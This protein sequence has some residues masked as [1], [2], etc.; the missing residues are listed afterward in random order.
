M[1]KVLA[2]TLLLVLLAVPAAVSA[3]KKGV[4]VDAKTFPDVNFR[5]WVRW[6]VCGESDF[7]PDETRLG[8]TEFD[9]DGYLEELGHFE[10]LK[11]IEYFPN[12]KKLT[13][14]HVGLKKL[15]LSG[16]P[17]LEYLKCAQNE[18]TRLDLSGNP[19]LK[20]VDCRENQLREL[21]VS[22]CVSL[23]ELNCSRNRLP[24]LDVSKNKQLTDLDCGDNCL[25]ALDISK[26]GAL[27]RLICSDN[28]M[29]TLDLRTLG[30][31]AFVDCRSNHLYRID[32]DE[33]DPP[34]VQAALSSYPVTSE[35][36]KVDLK[37]IP[38]FEYDKMEILRG[39][40]LSGS[41]LTLDEEI[42]YWGQTVA[43]TL[44]ITRLSDEYLSFEVTVKPAVLKTVT[45][46]P[47]KTVYTGRPAEPRVTVKAKLCGSYYP[48]E[49]GVD[50][51]L[52]YS[53]NVEVG[54]GHVTVTGIGR[55]FTG[56]VTKKFT[57]APVRILKAELSRV[58]MPYTGKKQTPALTVTAKVD[59][60]TVTLTE[61][62]DYTVTCM[63]NVDAGTGR[64][65]VKGVGRFTGTITKR[66][67][68]TRVRLGSASV[69]SAVIYTGGEQTPAP[70]VKASV[71]GKTRRLKAGRDYTV[72]YKRNVDA[73]TA[74]MT[75]KGIG[76]YI[77]TIKK[78]FTV[79]P[80]KILYAVLDSDI[81]PWTGEPVTPAPTVTA[82]VGGETVTLEEGKDYTVEY[83][84]NIDP[85]TGR[86]VITGKG[87]FTGSITKTFTILPP[88]E[89][90]PD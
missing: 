82:K 15:D 23:T 14:F 83:R 5:A 76:N 73:G 87:N 84:G 34:A 19:K 74:E 70:T 24:R 40:T 75:V 68:I 50:Y 44:P 29:T 2:M 27:R 90:E 16:N 12:L 18:L 62:K 77:G 86:A 81:L 64:V 71:N 53:D 17:K 51:T 80:V 8:I 49:E 10:T 6:V 65:T 11:G 32:Y 48:L 35:G 30:R 67:V 61:G 79:K 13:L 26:N 69:R 46:S 25:T 63:N 38:G 57:V 56:T 1:K 66:F 9:F 42:F 3:G 59:G 47:K 89:E 20:Y 45:V 33:D 55:F 22:G 28:R 37:K 7:L 31:Q 39:G 78:T 4:T 41:V 88:A 85:G 72:T 36:N 60:E 52:A 54:T 43:Y 58:K 21:D